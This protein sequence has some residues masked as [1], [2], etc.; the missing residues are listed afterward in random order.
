MTNVSFGAAFGT[1]ARLYFS[2]R[3]ILR[4]AVADGRL[5]AGKGPLGVPGFDLYAGGRA[6]RVL[7][8]RRHEAGAHIL[9]S[10]RNARILARE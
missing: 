4:A 10:P 7:D 2:G 9:P 1:R 8:P 3:R 5:R 6:A